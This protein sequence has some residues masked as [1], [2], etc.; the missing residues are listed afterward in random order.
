[1]ARKSRAGI[2]Q[3]TLAA[4]EAGGYSLPDGTPVSIDAANQAC[5]AATRLYEPGELARLALDERPA[6][7][8][9]RSVRVEVRNETTLSGIARL[10]AAG[11]REI[12]VLNFASARNPGGGFLGGSQAQEESL[13]RSSALYASL[14]S[15]WPYYERHRAQASL[16]YSDAAIFSPGCPVFRDDD[17][18]FHAPWLVHFITCAAPNAGAVQANQPQDVEQIPRVLARR[19]EGVLALAAS[20]GCRALILG[21][22]GCGVFRNDPAQVAHVFRELLFGAADWSLRFEALVFSVFDAS[23]TAP[24][25]RAFDDAFRDFR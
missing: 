7:G 17:G 21:A 16:L 3:T 14:M 22:W 25:F 5:I 8:G 20:R 23:E 2:A 6:P 1:V 9:E 19:A 18:V 13:A 4:I 10:H 11:H 24:T 15:A 12:A